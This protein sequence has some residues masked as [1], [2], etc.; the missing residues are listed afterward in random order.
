MKNLIFVILLLATSL[1]FAQEPAN[2]DPNCV[3]NAHDPFEPRVRMPSGPE[4][5]LCI[6]SKYRR[7]ARQLSA[8]A[9]ARYFTE[10]DGS[11]VVANFS[12]LKKFW[13]AQIPV[14]QIK[15]IIL[16]TQ[17]FP[18]MGM[19]ISHVQL[20]FDF[21]AGAKIKLISQDASGPAKTLSV[22][23]VLLSVENIGPHGEKFDFMKGMKGY[24]NLVYRLV[25][26]EDKYDWMIT[27][28]GHRVTQH[29]LKISPKNAQKV[30]MEGVSRGTARGSKTSYHSIHQSCSTELIKI[31]KA[32]LGTR[33]SVRSFHPNL[34]VDI[35]KN[36][37][38][39]QGQLQT[40]N[41]E[42]RSGM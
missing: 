40:L 1:A 37:N 41:E 21:T 23:H 36:R 25:S 39:I 12:H 32:T 8:N 26:L 20:R 22:K 30:F 31:F 18:V 6:N 3:T 29:L 42:F 27:Q 35:L 33:D 17:F 10:K 13:V 7:S 4:K 15:H 34:I 5:G 38:L 19:E 28:Q 2:T 9:A 16:Q 14:K 11:I 24:F